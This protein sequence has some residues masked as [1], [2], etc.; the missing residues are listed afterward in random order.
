M[1]RAESV[2]QWWTCLSESIPYM[3]LLPGGSMRCLGSTNKWR[4]WYL[5]KQSRLW[6]YMPTNV[7]Q[8]LYCEWLIL[9]PGRHIDGSNV[10]GT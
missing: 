6:I 7:Q 5:H 2:F 9:L 1:L 8:R 10:P 4:K 3:C